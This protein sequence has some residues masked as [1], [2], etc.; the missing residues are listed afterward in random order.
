MSDYDP[1]DDPFV[2]SRCGVYLSEH[3][4]VRGVYCDSCQIEIADMLSIPEEERDW[5]GRPEVPFRD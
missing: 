1:A 3:D 5:F 4:R 2:C